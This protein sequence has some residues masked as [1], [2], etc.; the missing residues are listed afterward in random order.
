MMNEKQEKF[1]HIILVALAIFLLGVQIGIR[2]GIKLER[3]RININYD[4][5]AAN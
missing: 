5:E 2:Q 3:E 4:Y 1:F